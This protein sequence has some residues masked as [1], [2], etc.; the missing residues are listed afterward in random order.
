MKTVFSAS[1]LPQIEISGEG[2]T[3]VASA[4]TSP[5]CQL[6]YGKALLGLTAIAAAEARTA[7]ATN[8]S[9]VPITNI[10]TTS[11]RFSAECIGIPDIRSGVV[12]ALVGLGPKFNQ[13]YIVE[14]STHIFDDTHGFR[15]KF[16]GEIQLL[17]H[18]GF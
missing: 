14:K 5:L 13:N 12:V 18:K 10:P 2:K 8:L 1:H 7:K 17:M 11:L 3:N 9:R 4:A 6:T 15:T 16:E